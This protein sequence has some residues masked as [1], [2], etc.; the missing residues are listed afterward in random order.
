VAFAIDVNS[1][2][3]VNKKYTYETTNWFAKYLRER[4][5]N[6]M[7]EGQPLFYEVDVTHME[8]L[9]VPMPTRYTQ[10]VKD[11]FDAKCS[12]ALGAQYFYQDSTGKSVVAEWREFSIRDFVNALIRRGDIPGLNDN[13]VVLIEFR[14]WSGS[15][16][17][18]QLANNRTCAV[19]E[20]DPPVRPFEKAPPHDD[21]VLYM[22]QGARVKLHPD[23]KG[24]L[25]DT[26]FLNPGFEAGY[27]FPGL[28]HPKSG[29]GTMQRHI[30]AAGDGD[31]PNNP[32]GQT[33]L[34]TFFSPKP[35]PNAQPAAPVVKAKAKRKAGKAQS[36][37]VTEHPPPRSGGAPAHAPNH[38]PPPPPS[39]PPP[40]DDTPAVAGPAKGAA[41][42]PAVPVGPA[43]PGPPEYPFPWDT[44]GGGKGDDPS[45][46]GKGAGGGNGGDG[47]T[48][49]DDSGWGGWAP[50]GADGG[51][52]GWTWSHTASGD[53]NRGG[54]GSGWGW[55]DTDGAN[56]SAGGAHGS[57]DWPGSAADAANRGGNDG[58]WG[59]WATAGADGGKG[60]DPA[61]A[62][63]GKGATRAMPNRWSRG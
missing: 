18:K 19:L 53:A 5:K 21:F 17:D 14:S 50:A 52:G 54:D 42:P 24:R 28:R 63:G 3:P 15:S 47:G 2:A 16:D 57:W 12:S 60:G 8:P 10:E 40:G 25:K 33:P 58:G 7:L 37:V 23:T 6:P 35:S 31:D 45:D 9:Q 34:A 51:W 26:K 62:N 1:Q 27:T 48:H 29:P 4:A 56:G 38:E 46:K 11:S 49:T 61:G 55:W 39:R 32:V 41:P 43:V 13:E 30:M 20:L 36:S 59:G 44:A 22:K